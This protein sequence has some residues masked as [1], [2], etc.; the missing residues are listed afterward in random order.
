MAVSDLPEDLL[1]KLEGWEANQP[2]NKTVRLLEDIAAMV[3]EAVM[4]MGEAPDDTNE[5]QK[6]AIL[7]DIRE[8]LAAI[9]DKE[10]KEL[11]DFSKPIVDVIAKLDKSFADAI[12]SI[13]VKPT[14]EAPQV[15][16]DA[17]KIDLSGVERILKKDVPEAF[18]KAIAA[19]PKTEVNIPETDNSSLENLLQE[20]SEKLSDIDTATRMK[21]IP[22]SMKIS[23]LGE[24]S[25]E[26]LTV[27]KA[28]SEVIQV[29]DANNTYI[30]QSIP[31]TPLAEASWRIKKVVVSGDTTTIYWADGDGGFTKQWTQRAVYSYV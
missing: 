16:V 8:S 27:K 4:V 10:Q 19:I 3:Q 7:V 15:R 17:P 23:N 22:G 24:I 13:D 6:G 30:G 5:K 26:S 9:R 29:V 14:V 25:P 11:P 31:G 21:P 12:K 20:V 2:Q 28:L 1:K 18:K